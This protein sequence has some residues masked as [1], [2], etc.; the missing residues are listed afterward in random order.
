MTGMDQEVELELFRLNKKKFLL[1]VLDVLEEAKGCFG[2]HCFNDGQQ[3]EAVY[4]RSRPLHEKLKK[5]R[6]SGLL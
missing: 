4:R 6:K 2:E 1:E 3:A 5:W